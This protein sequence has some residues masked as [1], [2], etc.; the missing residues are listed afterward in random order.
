[1]QSNYIGSVFTLGITINN[2]ESVK[3]GTKYPFETS[4][5]FNQSKKITKIVT[6]VSTDER[7]IIQINF[8]SGKVRLCTLGY[9]DDVLKKY[10]PRGRVIAFA[11]CGR[12]AAI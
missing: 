4:H 2:G 3:S 12:I 1:M 7:E 9:D 6:I 8:Y 11:K 5:V 10:H